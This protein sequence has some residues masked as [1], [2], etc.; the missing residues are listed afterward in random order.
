MREN[1]NKQSGTITNYYQFIIIMLI[2][3]L[4]TLCMHKTPVEICR[5]KE[6][7]TILVYGSLQ[8]GSLH[9]S[10]LC[11][12]FISIL[13]NVPQSKGIKANLK[14]FRHEIKPTRAI[15]I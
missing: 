1:Q 13:L 5:R 3:V 8:C 15:T 7:R 14:A 6:I 10:Q 9:F 11:C 4:A 12:S 2:T